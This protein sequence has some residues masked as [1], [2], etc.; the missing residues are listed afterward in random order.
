MNLDHE[1]QS[2]AETIPFE[3]VPQLASN[4]DFVEKAERARIV[5]RDLEALEKEYKD[6]GLELGAMI[7]VA[8]QRSVAYLDLVVLNVAGGETKGKLT[9]DRLLAS[10][11]DKAEAIA[12]AAKD[13]DPKILIE[14]GFPPSLIESSREPGKPRA[15]S[16][17]LRWVGGSGRGARQRSKGS[18]GPI[19]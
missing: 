4:P 2:A 15:G 10:A 1:D 18:G 17:Q 7:A 6:L 16:S 12:L 8:D 11:P 13:C 9:G 14:N 3:A 5:K 19:Q